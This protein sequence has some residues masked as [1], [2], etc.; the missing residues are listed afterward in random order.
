[1]SISASTAKSATTFSFMAAVA[2]GEI[3]N[4]PLLLTAL[5]LERERGRLRA[6]E[7]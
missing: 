7:G 2:G 6:A 3:A 4:A 1:L 5:W